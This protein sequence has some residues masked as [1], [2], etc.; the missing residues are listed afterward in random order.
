VS[1]L[2]PAHDAAGVI[3]DAL[4]SLQTQTYADWEAIV[5]DDASADDT[6]AQA[7]GVGDPRFRALRSETNLG[8]AGARNLAARQAS[9][10]LVAL[11]DADDRW[12]PGYL[13]RQVGRYDAE[14]AR[15]VDVGVV[16]CDAL[17]VDADGRELGSTWRAALPPY[18]PPTLDRLLRGNFIFVSALFPRAVG[19]EVGWF[20]TELFGTEDHDLWIRILETGRAAVLNAEAL[21]AYRVAGGSVSANLG[22]MAASYQRTL[23]RALG[24][25]RLT[26]RQQRIARSELRY[27][28]A[29]EAVA[30]ARFDRRRPL[31]QRA[32]RLLAELPALV[33]VAVTRTDRW[34]AWA[35]ALRYGR[36]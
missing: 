9:G 34:R 23:T 26:P 22:R 8:P 30:R 19:E 6:L 24:R 13:E 20:A 33:W 29:M 35:R 7:Q 36:A 18:D 12:L 27:Y 32:R 4:R 14:R 1:V 15:G 11:L 17:L 21:V 28:R 2:I 31:A 5:V 10:E 16:G 3:G 25:G